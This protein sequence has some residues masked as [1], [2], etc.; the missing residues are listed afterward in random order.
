MFIQGSWAAPSIEAA[1]PD[2][3]FDMF[4]MPNDSGDIQQPLGLDTGLCL[5][6]E[7]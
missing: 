6:A 5:G 3:N 4:P 1:N 2:K 7:R